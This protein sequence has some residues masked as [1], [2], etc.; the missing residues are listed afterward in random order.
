MAEKATAVSFRYGSRGDHTA[1]R[2]VKGEV[3]VDVETPTV[4]VHTGDQTKPGT[5]LACE[6][7]SNVA[8]TAITGKGIAKDDLTNVTISDTGT[9]RTRLNVL[10]YAQ[11]DLSDITD[12][13]FDVLNDKYATKTLSNVNASSITAI[14]G[15]NT[16]V[17]KDLSNVE[18]NDLAAKGLA[19][20]DLSNLTPNALSNAHIASDTLDN[21]TL[22]DTMRDTSHLD[23]QKVSK[24]VSLSGTVADDGS[25][26]SA[27]SVKQ[28][29]DAIPATITNIVVDTDTTSPNAGQVTITVSKDISNS[30]TI[31]TLAGQALSG[32][33]TKGGAN[34]IFTPADATVVV[35]V[36]TDNW[37]IKLI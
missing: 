9:V 32:T 19:K 21:V 33:W 7:L 18:G 8:Q 37:V 14:L 20:Y 16:Y 3:T 10:N 30:P 2:G 25:Y 34:W 28:A 17:K 31:S 11:R 12:S 15:N 23:L 35:T 13:G 1:F 22:T 24:L 27:Y 5:P 36:L 26:P 29:I 6:D 4:W